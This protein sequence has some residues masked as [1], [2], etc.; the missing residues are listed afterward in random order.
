[1]HHDKK[2]DAPSGTAIKTAIMIAAGRS[3]EPTLSQCIE[4]VAGARGAMYQQTPIHSVR[5]P[6]FLAH[7]RVI[8]G[9]LGETLTIQHDSIS[10]ACFM[11]GVLLACR[12]VMALTQL[13]YGLENIIA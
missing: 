4:S 3:E 11:P 13:V 9:G 12:K 10:R 2:Q 1:L 6:G 5:L 8:F 7:Q